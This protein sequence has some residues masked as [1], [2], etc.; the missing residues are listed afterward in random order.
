MLHEIKPSKGSRTPRKRAG[1]GNSAGR[2]TTAGRGTKGQQSRAGRGRKFGFEGGQ[3]PLLRRQPKFG[4][5][6]NVNRKEFEVIN[7][8][9][10]EQ[11]LDSGAY[12][13]AALKER[14]LIRTRK[15]VK[16]LGRQGLKKKFN[17]T[18]HAVS[19][20]AKEAIEKAGGKIQILQS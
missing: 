9:V 1:R 20:S 17:L 3:T 14:K 5:F 16:I 6:R 11:K 4:G 18:V 15:P 10:L 7:I 13:V 19:K 12:D 8:S 2:G